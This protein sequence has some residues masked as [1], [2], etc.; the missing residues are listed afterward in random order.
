M[1]D[2][3]A[4]VIRVGLS[5]TTVGEDTRLSKTLSYWLRHRPGAADLLLG[6]QGWAEVEAILA[7]LARSGNPTRL[8]RLRTVVD[9]NDKQRFELSPDGKRLR[10]RQG[11]SVAV[12]LDSP[13]VIP[14]DLLYHGTVE[15]NLDATRDDAAAQVAS[16]DEIRRR[17][18]A[19]ADIITG[20]AGAEAPL[21][22]GKLILRGGATA[23]AAASR[24]SVAGG[25]N[26]KESRSTRRSARDPRREGA[27]SLFW[28]NTLLPDRQ[29]CLAR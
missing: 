23:G 2:R 26:C 18:G 24:P 19:A 6:A 29:R 12:T 17:Q 16:D 20:A 13:A 10:A 11:H 28:R 22:G 1:R 25:R 3:A 8:D 14:P 21:T 5:V 27:G 4:G 9:R 15:R 7:A